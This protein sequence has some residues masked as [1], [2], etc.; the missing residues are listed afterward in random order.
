MTVAIVAAMYYGG[1]YVD[2]I[3]FLSEHRYIGYHM[4]RGQFSTR[5]NRVAHS[6]LSIFQFLAEHWKELNEEAIY[7]IDTYAI[8]VCDN[9]R[10]PRSKIYTEEVYRSIKRASG[11]ISM[12]SKFT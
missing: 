4:S 11:A 2:S 6:F 3:D 9:I 5:L 7:F 8:P 1:Y 12:A 10:I